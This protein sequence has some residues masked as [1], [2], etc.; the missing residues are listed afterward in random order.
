MA[1]ASGYVLGDGGLLNELSVNQRNNIYW[2]VVYIKQG[3]GMYLLESSLLCLNEGDL[4]VLPPGTQF[5]FS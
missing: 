2:T 1:M 5:C 3:V 4:I